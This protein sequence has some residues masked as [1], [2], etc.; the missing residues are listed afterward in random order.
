[1]ERGMEHLSPPP[2]VL[3]PLSELASVLESG[4][5]RCVLYVSTFMYTIFPVTKCTQVIINESNN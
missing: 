3:P 4:R 1:M 5:R 2:P